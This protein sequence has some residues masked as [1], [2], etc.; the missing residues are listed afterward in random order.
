MFKHDIKVGESIIVGD[1]VVT[2]QAKS[3]QICTLLIDAPP[4]VPIKTT[5]DRKK[6]EENAPQEPV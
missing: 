6:R 1:A 4:H 3:G 2:I 5:K